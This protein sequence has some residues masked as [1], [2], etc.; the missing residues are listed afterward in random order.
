MLKCF[1]RLPAEARNQLRKVLENVTT[2][3]VDWMARVF[4]IADFLAALASYHVLFEGRASMPRYPEKGWTLLSIS[5]R[6]AIV[7]ASKKII[8]I[9]SRQ[10]LLD[11]LSNFI[12][13]EIKHDKSKA[14]YEEV[15][16]YI[17]ELRSAA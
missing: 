3:F 2:I 16:K 4:Y 14:V 6:S 12:R 11:V 10:E 1:E 17:R 15:A 7:K 5:E 8:D 13:G 9:I